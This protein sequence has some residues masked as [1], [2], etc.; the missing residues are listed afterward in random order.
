MESV[1]VSTFDM[2]SRRPLNTSAKH[3][4]PKHP[5]PKGALL[6]PFLATVLHSPP[7]SGAT[8]HPRGNTMTD[9][10]AASWERP[11]L[12]ELHLHV[13]VMVAKREA[14]LEISLSENLTTL[15]HL[16]FFQP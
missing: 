14:L 9:D 5:H 15:I 8:K 1:E 10:T 2:V 16:G 12:P 3:L 7:L 11:L 6:T 13:A 4:P